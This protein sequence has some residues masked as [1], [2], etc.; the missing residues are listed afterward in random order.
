[1]QILQMPANTDIVALDKTP[2]LGG[3][4]REGI[5]NIE[6]PAVGVMLEGHNGVDLPAAGD[7]GWF[8]VFTG[9]AD[10][11]NVNLIADLPRWIRRGAAGGTA[12]ITLEG[13][14]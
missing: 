14:P 2:L 4:G 1:M 5:A 9:T 3:E 13:T 6:T 12:S 10:S 11:P 8:T 7:S